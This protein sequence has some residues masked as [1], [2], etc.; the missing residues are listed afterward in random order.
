MAR[1]RYKSEVREK[2]SD[3]V[4]RVSKNQDE[5]GKPKDIR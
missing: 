3:A 5:A 2:R 4:K 1:R